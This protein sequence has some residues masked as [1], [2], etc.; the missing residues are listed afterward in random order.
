MTS[1][2]GKKVE[3]IET[4]WVTDKTYQ[5]FVNG[6]AVTE[7]FDSRIRAVKVANWWM[8]GCPA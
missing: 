2:D 7:D 3:I 6:K 5:V 8:D 4:D 1:E